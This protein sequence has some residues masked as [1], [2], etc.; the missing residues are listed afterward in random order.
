MCKSENIRSL[1]W[2]YPLCDPCTIFYMAAHIWRTVLS[3]Q[4]SR[5]PDDK[6]MFY[7][8]SKIGP[9][10]L[11]IKFELMIWAWRTMFSLPTEKIWL[12]SYV[13][14]ARNLQMKPGH[15]KALKKEINVCLPPKKATFPG[16]ITCFL[17]N[18]SCIPSTFYQNKRFPSWL[19]SANRLD[20]NLV[21]Y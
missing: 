2:C 15:H 3:F 10:V 14:E 19:V 1:Y 13:C 11:D 12:K 16:Y 6:N 4:A 7:L 9:Y 18:D 21:G 20:T 17:N 8:Q 5:W